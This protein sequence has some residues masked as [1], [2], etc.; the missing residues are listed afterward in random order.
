MIKSYRGRI[1][2]D[3]IDKIPLHTN[4]GKTGYRIV[5]FQ[6]L[7][8]DADTQMENVIKIYKTKQTTVTTDIDFSDSTLL[9]AATLVNNNGNAYNPGPNIIFDNEVV[10]QDI[11]IT[12][13]GHD[14]TADANYYIELEQIKLSEIEA[15]V[16]IVEDLRQDQG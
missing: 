12:S 6:V 7:C 16:T 5:K 3:G 8:P 15:L 13:K 4:N 11:F 2:N 14:Q 1:V 10:N 9:A